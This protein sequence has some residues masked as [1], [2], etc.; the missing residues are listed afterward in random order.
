MPLTYGLAAGVWTSNLA[1]A[2]RMFRGLQT[3]T[4]W[5]NTYRKVLLPLE[6]RK[7]SGYGHD[8]VEANTREKAGIVEF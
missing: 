7:D 5:V 8:S 2:Q 4:V 6:G 1:T 3:G